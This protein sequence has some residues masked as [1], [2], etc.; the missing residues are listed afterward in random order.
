MG[1]ATT[2]DTKDTPDTKGRATH[3]FFVSCV[4]SVVIGFGEP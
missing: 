1:T 4:P 2:K 3:V